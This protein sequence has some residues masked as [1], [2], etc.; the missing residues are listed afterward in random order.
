LFSTPLHFFP[1]PSALLDSP[2]DRVGQHPGADPEDDASLLQRMCRPAGIGVALLGAR[3]PL[4][5]HGS[6]HGLGSGGVVP[7][8]PAPAPPAAAPFGPLGRLLRILILIRIWWSHRREGKVKVMTTSRGTSRP[9]K[10]AESHVLVLPAF[11]NGAI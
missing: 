11:P 2:A 6:V 10:V 7:I 5:L 8:L 1:A 4:H 9:I 3:L